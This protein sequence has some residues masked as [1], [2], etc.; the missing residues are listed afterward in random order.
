MPVA[1][2]D[3][4]VGQAACPVALPVAWQTPPSTLVED[5]VKGM[6]LDPEVSPSPGDLASSTRSGRL[7]MRDSE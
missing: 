1:A 3:T 6:E 4:P 5:P 7:R 2:R